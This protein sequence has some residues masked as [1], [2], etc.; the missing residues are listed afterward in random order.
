MGKRD[1]YSGAIIALTLNTADH[2]MAPSIL[3]LGDDAEGVILQDRTAAD[4]PQKTLLHATVKTYNRDFRGRLE[5]GDVLLY[6]TRH[7]HSAYNFDFN[8]DFAHSKPRN[9]YAEGHVTNMKHRRM[10][11]GRT[12]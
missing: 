7:D 12:R 3:T 4:T 5:K 8:R 2:V 1:S 10:T 9:Q 6:V 11:D